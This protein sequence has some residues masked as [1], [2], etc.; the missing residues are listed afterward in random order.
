MTRPTFD[1]L[2]EVVAEKRRHDAAVNYPLRKVVNHSV[3]TE[4]ETRNVMECGH[5]I[6]GRYISWAARC[7]ACGQKGGE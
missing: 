4:N 3:H 5:V 1:N 2:P 7:R 6:I